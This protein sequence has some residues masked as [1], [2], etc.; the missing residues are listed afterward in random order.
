MRTEGGRRGR[1]PGV[2]GTSDVPVEKDLDG[3][4]YWF[5]AKRYGWG[6]GVRKVWQGW[7]VLATY[8]ALV[9]AGALVFDL[10]ANALG[11][12]VY[13]VAVSLVLTGIC[14]LRGEP[15]KWRW[16]KGSEA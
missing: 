8:I 13:V 3:Q 11:Y 12:V 14:W 5:P 16:G 15:P 1:Q 6:W 4:K 2:L 10:K 9:P 7:V